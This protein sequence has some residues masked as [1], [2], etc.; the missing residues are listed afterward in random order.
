MARFRIGKLR[1][2][3]WVYGWHLERIFQKNE[4][5]D[6][7]VEALADKGAEALRTILKYWD[8]YQPLFNIVVSNEGQDTAQYVEDELKKI[9]DDLDAVKTIPDI[10]NDLEQYKLADDPD[11]NE[12][13][14][15]FL[16]SVAL[17]SNK[18]FSEF[19]LIGLS[20]QLAAFIK[21]K[22]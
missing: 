18:G 5:G 16:T 8:A 20:V 19:E 1:I 4:Q 2:G 3:D 12:F 22:A 6:I 15:D 13:Y 17:A 9:A 11:R 14:H 10:A 21:S 7:S